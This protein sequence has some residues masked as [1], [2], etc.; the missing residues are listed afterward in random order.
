VRWYGRKAWQI[1]R[2]QALF[3]SDYRCS[4]CG[5]SLVGLGQEAHVHHRKPLKSTPALGLEP[6]NL[7][8][9]CR[10][11]HSTIEMGERRGPIAAIDGTP[12]SP[13]H[14]WNQQ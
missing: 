9:V 10:D 11:C 14:P 5:R 4:R 3:D 6:L 1:A 2:K 7:M 13:T 12:A 8:A